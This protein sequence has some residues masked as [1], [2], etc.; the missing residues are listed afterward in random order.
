MRKGR[1]VICH[2]DDSPKLLRW[3]RK[4]VKEMKAEAPPKRDVS[5]SEVE[6]AAL[7]PESRS[8]LERWVETVLDRC[9]AGKLPAECLLDAEELRAVITDLAGRKCLLNA[10]IGPT[11]SKAH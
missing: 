6:A 9:T 4:A 3:L 7:S 8:Q 11:F 5:A 2:S 1:A 10:L